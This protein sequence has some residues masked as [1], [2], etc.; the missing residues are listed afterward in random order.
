MKTRIVRIGNSQGIRI[1]KLLLAE[2]GLAEEAEIEIELRRGE[3][4][5]RLAEEQPATY[6]AGEVREAAARWNAGT[7]TGEQAWVATLLDRLEAGEEVVLD[8][9]GRP[10]A[11]LVA[12]RSTPRRPGR[13]QGRLTI[14]DDF[15]APLPPEIAAA[16]RGEAG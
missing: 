3:L 5:I 1:P 11:K 4:V 9:D 2:A 15:D 13:L 16:F 7:E 6:R 12:I 8:R 10:A 14:A